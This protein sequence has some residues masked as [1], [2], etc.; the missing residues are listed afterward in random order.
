MA[1]FTAD[2][3]IEHINEFSYD[4]KKSIFHALKASLRRPR[5]IR[6]ARGNGKEPVITNSLLGIFKDDSITLDDIREERIARQ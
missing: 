6:L 3:V 4:E 5:K 2:E 1:A